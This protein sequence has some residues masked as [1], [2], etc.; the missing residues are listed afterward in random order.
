MAKAIKITNE[1]Q[2]QVTLYL[3][4]SVKLEIKI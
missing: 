2:N 4:N 1:E 3:F